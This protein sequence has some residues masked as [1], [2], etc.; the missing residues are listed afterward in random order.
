MA[1]SSLLQSRL[2]RPRYWTS[3]LALSV[4]WLTAKLPMPV[5]ALIGTALGELTYHLMSS[6][7]HIARRNIDACFSELSE[8]E[9]RRLVRD[10][11]Y[12]GRMVCVCQQT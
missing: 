2:H 10:V 1:R 3:W 4:L 11:W 5:L 6:R 9:R 12:Y 8:T 7:R